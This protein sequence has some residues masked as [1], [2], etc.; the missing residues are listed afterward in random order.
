MITFRRLGISLL[1]VLTL[2]IEAPL[3][4]AAPVSTSTIH[5][6]EDGTVAWSLPAGQCPSLPA[7]LVLSGNGERHKEINTK[8]T[9]S[10]TTKI[11]NDLVNGTASD[12]QGGTYHFKYT[13]H[14]IDIV[15]AGGTVHQISMDDSFVLNGNGSAKHMNIGFNWTWSYSDPM[16]P[17][18]V[19]P[20]A[21]LVE[22]STRGGNPLLCDPL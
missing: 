12:N 2:L 6:T 20:L 16:G 4:Y 18:D 19:I 7:G 11:I 15:S 3:A 14:S 13:N 21:N 9:A 5:E 8:V 22:R 1:F 17:F 10:D